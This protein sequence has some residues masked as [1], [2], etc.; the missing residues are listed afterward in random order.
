MYMVFGLPNSDN[1]LDSLFPICSDRERSQSRS[2]RAKI[3]S[4]EVKIGRNR[5]VIGG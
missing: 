2:K 5:T 4:D 3:G 1:Y